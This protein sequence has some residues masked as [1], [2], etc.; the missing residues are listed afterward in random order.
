MVSVP[1]VEIDGRPA[2]VEQ[3]QVLAQVNFGHYTSMQVRGG[4]VRGL[5]LH[6]A[7][8]AAGNRELFAA[9]LDPDEVR[10]QVRRAVGDGDASVRITAFVPDPEAAPS[11]VVG[12]QPPASAS[13]QPLR[14]HVVG[15]Q[16][17]VPHLKHVGTFAQLYYGRLARA[18]GF[19][20]ALLTS[21]DNVVSETAVANVGFLTAGTV[22]W[23]SAPILRGTGMQLLEHRLAETGWPAVFDRVR[24]RDLGSIDGAFV[25][26]ASGLAAVSQVDTDHLP[27][28][29]A[30]LARLAE[31]YE[32][33][34][35]DRI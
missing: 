8:L 12:V 24:L 17:P 34:E 3:L 25:V 28:N 31:L 1:R 19:D 11:L 7:R 30:G 20:D 15:Y 16:R 33:A 23:P 13:T 4:R 32:S 9:E 18:N 10:R 27:V 35:W 26:N 2:S 21:P 5:A 29:R 22:V 14:L 6:L